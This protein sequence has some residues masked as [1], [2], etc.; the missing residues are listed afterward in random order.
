[1]FAATSYNFWIAVL[2]TL[3]CA[4]VVF[5]L[6]HSGRLRELFLRTTWAAVQASRHWLHLRSMKCTTWELSVRLTVYSVNVRN[7]RRSISS[8]GCQFTAFAATLCFFYCQVSICFSVRA[9]YCCHLCLSVCLSVRPSACQTHGLRQNEIIVC[10]RCFLYLSK[11]C[12]SEFR[13]S[14]KASVLNSSTPQPK[15]QIW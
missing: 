1:M 2:E 5:M 8:A 14:S 13:G 11:F 12:G 3:K 15:A 9:C 7:V 4:A 6:V 10:Q